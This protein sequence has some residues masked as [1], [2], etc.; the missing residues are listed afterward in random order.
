ML[1]FLVGKEPMAPADIAKA[2]SYDQKAIHSLL[3]KAK[4]QKLLDATIVP[5]PGT[6]GLSLFSI[7]KRG[8][9]ALNTP[10][11]V[12]KNHWGK[13]L[14]AFSKASVSCFK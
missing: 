14:G 2:I 6:R 12:K 9:E 7:S 11:V 4:Q 10:E 1:Q 3:S 5:V 13:S 8:E